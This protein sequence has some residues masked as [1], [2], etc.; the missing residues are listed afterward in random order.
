MR[1]LILISILSILLFI[2][3][4]FVYTDFR[5]NSNYIPR[6]HIKAV[7]A[8]QDSIL[9]L[10]RNKTYSRRGDSKSGTISLMTSHSWPIYNQY[11]VRIDE[12]NPHKVNFWSCLADFSPDDIMGVTDPNNLTDKDK[13]YLCEYIENTMCFLH[14]LNMIYFDGI[15]NTKQKAEGIECIV[16]LHYGQGMYYIPTFDSIADEE[17]KKDYKSVGSGWY[18]LK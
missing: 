12:E 7:I 2:V 11:S 14:S 13:E 9:N 18:I 6:R 15:M 1:K 5:W 3:G 17:F 10:A 8:N 4:V 16:V